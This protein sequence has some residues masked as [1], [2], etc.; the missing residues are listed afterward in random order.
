M[1][2][3]SMSIFNAT[4]LLYQM[5]SGIGWQEPGRESIWLHDEMVCRI[6]E[7]CRERKCWSGRIVIEMTGTQ[8]VN[9]LHDY[10]HAQFAKEWIFCASSW[11]AGWL[12]YLFQQ[13]WWWWCDCGGNHLE[14]MAVYQLQFKTIYRFF[15]LFVFFF[16]SLNRIIEFS[17]AR[18]LLDWGRYG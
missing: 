17:I 15:S 4:G 8:L 18:V 9:A 16:C 14:K 7:R 12:S 10:L 11:N 5:A 13:W 6:C 3:S 2:L 1:E